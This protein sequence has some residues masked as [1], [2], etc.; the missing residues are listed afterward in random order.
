MTERL[1]LLGLQMSE[2]NFS[3]SFSLEA[4]IFFIVDTSSR[5]SATYMTIQGKGGE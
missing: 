2:I 4:A 5:P 1:V 3:F